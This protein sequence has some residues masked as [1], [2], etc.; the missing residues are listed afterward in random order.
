MDSTEK[1]FNFVVG[2]KSYALPLP[3]IREVIALPQITA[4]PNS[5][6]HVAGLIN[7]RGQII[8]VF[9]LRSYLKDDNLKED[10]T[11]IIAEMKFGHIG[12]I[13][14]SVSSV[15]SID[16]KR[17]EKLPPEA[18]Q[19]DNNII[20]NIY[21]DGDQLVLLLDVEQIM[22]QETRLKTLLATKKPE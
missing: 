9:D 14:D 12:L 2:N 18:T 11:V 6:N 16:P 17:L 19:T 5:P 22:D 10:A 15:V 1:S 20:A 4:V 7:L 8:T 3:R 13:V 21:S